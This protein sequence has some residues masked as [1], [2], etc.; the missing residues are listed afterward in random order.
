MTSGVLC[1]LL[2][3]IFIPR[4]ERW[5]LSLRTPR[6][7]LDFHE[8]KKGT[9]TMG[10][11]LLVASITV[12]TLLWAD[13]SNRFVHMVLFVL[14]SMGVLGAVDDWQQMNRE[15]NRGLSARTKFL[16]QGGVALVVGLW[17]IQ[18]PIPVRLLWIDEVFRYD[19][20]RSV[21][22]P[23]L[24]SF[25]LP[26]GLMYI[27]FV[28]IVIMGSSN[29]V[30]LT[31]GLDGLAAGSVVFVAVAYAAI[32]YI[33][34]HYV[35][36]RYLQIPNIRG[37]AELTIFV[38]SIIG[39]GLG[40]LWFNAPPAQ[41]FMGDAGSLSL[42]GALGTTAVLIKQELLL[43]LVGGIFVVEALSVM[44][45]VLY[46]RMTGKRV[47]RMAPLHHHFELKGMD[48]CKITM[49]FWIVGIIFAL[50]ALSTLK[51]R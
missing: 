30:N 7:E 14:L 12:S 31:D 43:V 36:S 47:F 2:G 39:S 4:F 38:A 46:Y 26:L 42:G 40:F 1:W 45:Q 29:A 20:T 19:L 33:S 10:G 32:A 18:K 22:L 28:M 17:L 25:W 15:D 41:I 6:R 35:F 49:R 16:I 11:L 13:L 21:F 48:E 50:L 27:P 51:L 24:K 8:E 5:D 37:G 23:F 44:I 9:P 3:R 34:G